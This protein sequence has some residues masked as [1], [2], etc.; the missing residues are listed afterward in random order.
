MYNYNMNQKI[1]DILE[2]VI[3]MKKNPQEEKE[4]FR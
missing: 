3:M 1:R 2:V 4:K